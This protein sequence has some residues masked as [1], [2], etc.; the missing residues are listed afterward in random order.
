MS[1][2]LPAPVYTRQSLNPTRVL[3][4][5]HK[6]LQEERRVNN[7]SEMG[8]ERL[9]AILEQGLQYKVSLLGNNGKALTVG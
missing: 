9:G 8:R 7:L 6:P 2:N 4:V 5:Y 3:A 1:N